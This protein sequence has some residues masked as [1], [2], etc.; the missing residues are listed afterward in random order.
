[1]ETERQS[2]MDKVP[3]PPVAAIIYGEITYR[4]AITGLVIS[5]AG[6]GIYLIFGGYLDK[7]AITRDI[8]SGETVKT[9]WKDS[10]GVTGVPGNYWYLGRLAKGDCLAMLGIVIAC[11]ASLIGMWGAAFGMLRSKGGI[12]II[13]AVIIAVILTLSA[14]GIISI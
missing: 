8:W 5:M 10:A 13:F 7:A 3:K 14:S 9:I 2:E 12:Y 11:L 6:I 1:M 4:V